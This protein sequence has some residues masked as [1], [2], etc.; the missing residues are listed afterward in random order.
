[1]LSLNLIQK[2][3][4]LGFSS[5]QIRNMYK[6][7]KMFNEVVECETLEDIKILLLHWIETGKIK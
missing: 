5:E 1:M 3:R 6:R 4:E 2:G 7:E